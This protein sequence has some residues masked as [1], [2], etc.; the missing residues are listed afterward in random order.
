MLIY[1]PSFLVPLPV[2]LLLALFLENKEKNI[3]DSINDAI[4]KNRSLV[5]VWNLNI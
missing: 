3:L 1:I 4:S 5:F 2:L